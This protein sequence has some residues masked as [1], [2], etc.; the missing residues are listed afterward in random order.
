[1]ASAPGAAQ[2]ALRFIGCIPLITF[3]LSARGD[4]TGSRGGERRRRSPVVADL[5]GSEKKRL[6]HPFEAALTHVKGRIRPADSGA[7]LP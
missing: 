6:C 5:A 1:V 2:R 7:G 3:I 4:A